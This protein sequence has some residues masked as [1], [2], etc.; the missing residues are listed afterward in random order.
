MCLNEHHYMANI[1]CTK[2]LEKLVGKNLISTEPLTGELLGNWNANI[3]TM[4][5]RK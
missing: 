5:K 1:F 3:F 4:N 2:K